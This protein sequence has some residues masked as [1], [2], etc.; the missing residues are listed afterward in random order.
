MKAGESLPDRRRDTRSS[1]PGSTVP[2]TQIAAVE[3]REATR[4]L[5]A[6]EA[7]RRHLRLA[8]LHAP[9]CLRGVKLK[10]ATRVMRGSNSACA[11]EPCANGHGCLKIESGIAGEAGQTLGVVPAQAGTHNHRTLRELRDGRSSISHTSKLREY[12]SRPSPGRPGR[13]SATSNPGVRGDDVAEQRG[14][15]PRS[16]QLTAFRAPACRFPEWFP[17]PAARRHPACACG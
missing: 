5:F 6:E 10:S 13:D 14:V 4:F 9:R 7:K 11:N 16:N 12:G 3:R 17:V 1:C 2:W 15:L 8:A